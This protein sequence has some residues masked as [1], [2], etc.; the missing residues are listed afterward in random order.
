MHIF[1]L[2]KRISLPPSHSGRPMRNSIN[3]LNCVG[4]TRAVTEIGFDGL[5]VN[6]LSASIILFGQVDLVIAKTVFSTCVLPTSAKSAE[7]SMS[8]VNAVVYRGYFISE[9]DTIEG[10]IKIRENL[11]INLSLG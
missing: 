11:P 2:Y 4:G 9:A 7:R 10:C 1:A 5:L 3:E 6:P 8:D